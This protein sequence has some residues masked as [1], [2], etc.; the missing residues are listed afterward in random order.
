MTGCPTAGRTGYSD[1]MR[2]LDKTELVF[3]AIMLLVLAPV[4]YF[5]ARKLIALMG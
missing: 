2:R 3:V 5:I 4:A 1:I